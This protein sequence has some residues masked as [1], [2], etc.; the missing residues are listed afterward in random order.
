[1]IVILKCIKFFFLAKYEGFRERF[2][3]KRIKCWTEVLH[4][5]KVKSKGKCN[6]GV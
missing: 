2:F 6:G 4:E 3:G 1:M 5:R